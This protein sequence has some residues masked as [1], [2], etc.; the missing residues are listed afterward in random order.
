MINH[1]FKPWYST[2]LKVEWNWTQNAD[3]KK[4]R[5]YNDGMKL[6]EVNEG[7]EQINE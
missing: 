6:L 4:E 3:E 1:V 5:K 7:I 2:V